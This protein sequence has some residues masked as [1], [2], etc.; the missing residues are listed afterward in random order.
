MP[1]SWGYRNRLR[2]RS[3]V[4]KNG[5]KVKPVERVHKGTLKGTGLRGDSFSSAA[6]DLRINDLRMQT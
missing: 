4:S 5:S 3:V 6:N 2:E 1:S